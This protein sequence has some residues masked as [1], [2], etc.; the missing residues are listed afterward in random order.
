M[1][2]NFDVNDRRRQAADDK[3]MNT[4]RQLFGSIRQH[5]MVSAGLVIFLLGGMTLWTGVTNIAGAVVAAGTVVVESNV[6]QVQHQDGGIVKNIYVEDGDLVEADDLLFV[7]DDTLLRS[8]WEFVTKQL[9]ELYA[10]HG[11]LL[12]EQQEKEKIDFSRYVWVN[13]DDVLTQQVKKNQQ[14]LFTARRNSLAG[15]KNQLREQI[16]QL[17]QKN[18]GVQSQIEAKEREIELVSEQLSSIRSLLK[19]DFATKSDVMDREREFAQLQGDYGSLIA[20]IAQDKEAISE[21][22]MQILQLED[23]YRA[24]ILHSLQDTRVSIA[25]LEKQKIILDEQLERLFIKAPHSGYIHNLVIHTIGGIVSPAEA[26]MAIVPQKDVLVI[27]AKI[28][29]VDIEQLLPD[30][31]ARVRFPSFDQKETPELQSILKVISADLLFDQTTGESY[32][33]ARFAIPE[34]ELSKLNGKHLIP[35]MPVEVFAK[36]ED[37]SVLSYLVK[38]INDQIAYALRER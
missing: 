13:E 23:D 22:Q 31:H 35:G 32:Y 28:R 30:Q 20:S 27:E 2:P 16:A 26:I 3:T 29:P 18:S 25:E 4:E 5:I 19:S 14:G 7:L 24:E 36:T 1:V 37:R 10:Q 12:A 33:L 15:Q 11:R 17:Q 6:K 34:V 8:E 9:N 38:P 21:K